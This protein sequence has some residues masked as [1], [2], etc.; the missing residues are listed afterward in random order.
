MLGLN[1]SKFFSLFFSIWGESGTCTVLC[2]QWIQVYIGLNA[3]DNACCWGSWKQAL[4]LLVS[5]SISFLFYKLEIRIPKPHGSSMHLLGEHVRCWTQLL[6]RLMHFIN[7]RC[8]RANSV[9]CYGGT[10]WGHMRKFPNF[11]LSGFNWLIPVRSKYSAVSEKYLNIEPYLAFFQSTK[12]D[13][14]CDEVG[15]SH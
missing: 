11:H 1:R 4:S 14:R 2:S 12:M 10:V 13:V 6:T 15:V 3:D 8:C 9:L 7:D 5:S